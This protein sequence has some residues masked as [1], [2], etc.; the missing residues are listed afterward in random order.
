MNDENKRT[1]VVAGTAFCIGVVGLT[2]G[3]S[4]LRLNEAK[5]IIRLHYS[6]YRWIRGV[7]RFVFACFIGFGLANFVRIVSSLI[8]DKREANLA[9]ARL[10]QQQRD[11]KLETPESILNHLKAMLL[12]EESDEVSEWLKK[13]ISQ[14]EVMNELQNRLNELLS[15][16]DVS[17][18][19]GVKDLLQKVE[20]AICF[21]KV[22]RLINYYTGGGE[23]LFLQNAQ[24]IHS[25]IRDL[26]EQAQKLVNYVVDFVNSNNNTDT[27][28]KLQISS[29]MQTIQSFLE[30]D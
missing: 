10:A 17:S 3:L 13:L 20:N 23:T 22:K 8:Q 24:E 16:N 1:L 9:S 7:I 14:L 21:S 19:D 25:E 4:L 2:V 5:L 28:V 12:E 18:L 29:F 30:E 15:T 27:D 11:S 26:L 6:G